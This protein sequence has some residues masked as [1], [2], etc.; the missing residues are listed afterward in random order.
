M[1]LLQSQS[2]LLSQMTTSLQDI[3][4]SI[5]SVGEKLNTQ[6]EIVKSLSETFEKGKNELKSINTSL[7]SLISESEKLKKIDVKKLKKILNITTSKNSSL[8]LNASSALEEH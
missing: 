1:D 3:S 7:E 4:K 2:E 8:G 5:K 6:A